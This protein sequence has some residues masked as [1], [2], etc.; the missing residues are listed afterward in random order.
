V[1]D[2]V[3][4]TPAL[5][6]LRQHFTGAHIS[7][8]VKPS[9]KPVIE[10]LPFF[11]AIIEYEP[12]GRDRG[13]KRYSAVVRQLRQR[14]FD[15]G[16][17]MPHSFSSALLFFLAGISVRAGYD[18]NVRGWMLTRKVAP[19]RSNGKIV[20]VNMV[21]LYL[22]LVKSL[23]C[24]VIDE[25]VELKTSATAEKWVDEFFTTQCIAPDDLIIVIIPGATFGS[26]KCWQDSS[27][28]RTADVL[29]RAHKAKILILPG[30]GEMEIAQSIIRKMEQPPVGIGD[31][32]LPL[33]LLMA[34]IR[35]CSLLITNDTGPRHFGVAFDRPVIVI[36]GPTDHRYTDYQLDNTM[37]LRE[38]LDCA[39]CHLKECP[40]D[41]RC[42]TS[43]TPERVLAAAREIIDT[44]Y[45][46][47]RQ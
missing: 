42:M 4:S 24:E 11:D 19:F 43:I 10:Q 14:S 33:D 6:S 31:R 22:H 9:L 21:R 20:P 46:E 17:L 15:L 18:R 28:A 12:K 13:W 29:I 3:M 25:R 38:T 16:I 5:R 47:Y 32:V 45:P 26:S 40:T 36:M 1:G 44:H 41:H 27:F 35:R 2:L 34:L 30:P 8:M 23:G 37:V 39:P 7:V